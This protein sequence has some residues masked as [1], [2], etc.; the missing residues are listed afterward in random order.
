MAQ[1]RADLDAQDLQT[2]LRIQ[3]NQQPAFK[4]WLATMTPPPPPA[5]PEPPTQPPT[6]PQMLDLMAKHDAERAAHMGQRMS[7]TRSLYAALSPDQQKVF[8][9]L[10]RLRRPMG[11]PRPPGG[12][13]GP[14]PM[15]P[16]G[17]PSF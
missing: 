16:G 17:P 12:P 11:P 6:A 15:G 9:A 7:A 1:A 14:G 5:L 10:Q 8:D 13:D 3:P 4:A 2:V